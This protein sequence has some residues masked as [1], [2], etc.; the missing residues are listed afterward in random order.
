MRSNIILRKTYV[1]VDLEKKEI[2]ERQQSHK[3]LT[4]RPLLLISY[5]AHIM[6]GKTDQEIQ[7]FIN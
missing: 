7:F 4:K 3:V 6:I 5:H 1:E 2:F